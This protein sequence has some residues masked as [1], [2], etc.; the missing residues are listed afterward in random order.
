MEKILTI[1]VKTEAPTF[2]KG[3]TKNILSIPFT[4]EAVGPA[5]FGETVGVGVDTQKIKDGKAFLSARYIL[6]GKDFNGTD[7]TLFIENNGE[8]LE[9]CRPMLVTDSEALAYLETS[10]LKAV[11][12]P[13]NGGVT[14]SIYVL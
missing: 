6:R 13:N 11:V 2:I 9:S 14:V 12:T 8:S 1:N 4:A 7:S 3:S 10:D 5:F